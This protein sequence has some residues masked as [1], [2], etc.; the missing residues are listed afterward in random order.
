MKKTKFTPKEVLS[1]IFED[2]LTVI[3]TTPLTFFFSLL[4]VCTL[5]HLLDSFLY[6]FM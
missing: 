6:L 2:C 3:S 5:Y 4:F 1:M